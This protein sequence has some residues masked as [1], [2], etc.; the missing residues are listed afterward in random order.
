MI[1]LLVK[2]LVKNKEVEKVIE[3]LKK[4][5]FVYTGKITPVGE[6]KYGL[7]ETNYYLDQLILE[8]IKTELYK[9]LMELDIFQVMLLITKIS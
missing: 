1:T 2:K 6:N 3:Y 5:N 7:K 8:M 9:S 4:N